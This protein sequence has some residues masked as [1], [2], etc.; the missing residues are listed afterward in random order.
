MKN[1]CYLTIIS[2][3]FLLSCNKETEGYIRAVTT[4]AADTNIAYID[5]M[6]P[7]GG[8]YCDKNFYLPVSYTRQQFSVMFDSSAIYK[9]TGQNNQMDINK[10]YG[11]SDNNSEHHVYSARIGWRWSND[12]L[13]LFAYVYNNEI[14]STKELCV[15]ALNN[16]ILCAIEVT[17]NQ[18]LFTVNG[19]VVTMPRGSSTGTGAGYKLYPYFGGDETA[20]HNIRIRI[21]EF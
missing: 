17:G 11:F 6:I 15:V 8:Q 7:E 20:P 12:S 2:L 1:Y 3:L 13:R 21:K 4:P 9:T 19:I 10:L 5:Y 16:E 14:R 18:Y